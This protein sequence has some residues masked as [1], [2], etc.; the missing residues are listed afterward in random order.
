MNPNGADNI[1]ADLEPSCG[2][3]R[4][5]GLHARLLAACDIGRQSAVIGD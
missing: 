3:V 1:S 2:P 5:G 4:A